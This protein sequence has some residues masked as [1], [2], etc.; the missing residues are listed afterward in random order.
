MCVCVCV[1]VCVCACTHLITVICSIIMLAQVMK[2]K[3][4][5]TSVKSLASKLDSKEQAKSL[6]EVI[7][8]LKKTITDARLRDT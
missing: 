4:A 8:A 1:C 3:S 2:L 5:A 7:R 6:D